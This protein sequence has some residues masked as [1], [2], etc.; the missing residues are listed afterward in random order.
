M[1]RHI[2]L[3]LASLRA[4]P[5]FTAVAIASLAVAMGLNILIFCFTDPALL[6]PLPYADT[7]TLLDVSMAPPGRP[8]ARGPLPPPLFF[9]LRDRTDAV[10]ASIGIF[11]ATRWANLS[12][13]AEGPAVR[14]DGHRITSG[15][16]AAFGARPIVGALPAATDE[17]HDAHATMV[18]SYDL[19]TTRFGRRTEVVN[20]TVQLDGTPTR[21]LGVMPQ[22]FGLLDRSSDAWFTYGFEPLTPTEETQHALRAVA[23]LKPGVSISQAQASVDAALGEYAQAF[24][25]RD[26]GWTIE[27]TPWR[28]ARFGAVRRPLAIVQMAV[29]SLLLLLCVNLAILWVARSMR[30][31]PSLAVSSER[32]PPSVVLTESLMLCLAGGAIGAAIT[33]AGLP[34]F[35]AMAPTVLPRLDDIRFGARV[36]AFSLVLSVVTGVVLAVIPAWRLSRR[37]TARERARETRHVWRERVAATLLAILVSA[38]VAVAFLLLTGA[39]FATRAFVGLRG[40]DVGIDPTHLLSADVHLPRTPYAIRGVDQ[41]GSIEIA[42]YDPAGPALYDRIR[43][44]LQSMPGAIDVAGVSAPPFTAA[45]FVQ[46]WTDDN[47]HTPDHQ[48]AAQYLAVTENYFKTMEMRIVRGRDFS[49]DDRANSPWVVLVNETMARQQWPDADPIGHRVTLT[50]HPNDEERSREIV[51]LV[52]DTLPFRGASEVPPLMYLLHRQQA[53]RQR[54]SFDARRTS[55]S[56]IV[57]TAGEPMALGE[58][59]RAAVAKVDITTPVAEVRTVQSYANAGQVL[60][61]QFV[62]VLLSLFA[63]AALVIAAAGIA[64]LAT[65]GVGPRRPLLTMGLRVVAALAIGGVAGRDVWLQVGDEIASFVENLTVAPPDPP[66]ML[67]AACMLSATAVVASVVSA[68]FS[69]A[70]RS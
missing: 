32:K 55:M 31:E 2:S 9:R 34:A 36:V 33:W 22:G 64:G 57:R 8:E 28:D 39:T 13:D 7:E 51:G 23:R 60:L 17:P 69:K 14:L 45:P 12:G 56:F 48:L 49:T 54:A 43:G 30:R 20:Q 70:S 65:Y 19:W 66:S 50:F 44:A 59:V 16:L 25:N 10:F 62:A 35:R 11:D 1:R 37:T 46:L 4:T 61:L 53:Q 52:A 3:A 47:E 38:Q 5:T 21:I 6:E 40:R 15:G 42:E 18:L 58:A 27:L 26:K 68:R 67:I 24:P 29:G 41:I 63:L